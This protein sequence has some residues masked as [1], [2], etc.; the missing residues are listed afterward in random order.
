MA[1]SAIRRQEL[2]VTVSS[3]CLQFDEQGTRKATVLTVKHARVPLR[4][5][6]HACHDCKRKRGQATFLAIVGVVRAGGGWTRGPARR[7]LSLASRWSRRV[8]GGLED[9]N[10]DG[11][12]IA[13]GMWL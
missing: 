9:G 8:A 12:E 10:R 5:Q 4:T 13:S 6:R 1:S 11:L 7:P 2:I 3:I